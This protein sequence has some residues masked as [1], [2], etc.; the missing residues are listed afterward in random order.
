MIKMIEKEKVHLE[1]PSSHFEI[2][3]SGEQVEFAGGMVRDIGRVK[4]RFFRVLAGPM[5][6][7]WAEHLHKGHIKYPDVSPGVANW[8]LAKGEEE[9]QR[10]KESALDH[11]IDWLKGKEDEDHGAAV[12][13]NINGAEYVKEVMKDGRGNQKDTET[14]GSSKI[15]C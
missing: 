1:E 12:F 9:L 4:V 7:R 14:C 13:F 6:R 11:M 8:T 15:G 3:S 10:F 2:K 5:L